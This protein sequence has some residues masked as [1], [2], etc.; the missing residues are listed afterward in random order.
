MGIFFADFTFY[1]KFCRIK[2]KSNTDYKYQI[3]LP[4]IEG[5]AINT[6]VV[7]NGRAPAAAKVR[8]S[9][10]PGNCATLSINDVDGANNMAVC[11]ISIFYIKTREKNTPQINVD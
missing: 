3:F 2:E 7:L 4:K 1:S 11:R 6:E 10:I 5:D 8:A 9:M